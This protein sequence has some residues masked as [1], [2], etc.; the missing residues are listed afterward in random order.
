M[1]D[2]F[3]IAIL[4]MIIGVNADAVELI[5]GNDLYES[6]LMVKKTD[7]LH[8]NA[9]NISIS[10]SHLMGYVRG[11]SESM[12][13][14]GGLCSNSAVSTR[15]LVDVVGRYLETKPEKRSLNAG[16]VVV[17]AIS[18]AFPCDHKESKHRESWKPVYWWPLI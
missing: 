15:Q 3:V 7:N 5:T 16:D 11:R 1:T 14:N 12:T 4:L 2:K 18:T 8:N 10:A 6:Y 13:Q 9:D 17:E